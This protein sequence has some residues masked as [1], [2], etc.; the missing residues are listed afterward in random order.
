MSTLDDNTCEYCQGLGCDNC[1]HECYTCAGQGRVRDNSDEEYE[2]CPDC[3][4]TGVSFVKEDYDFEPETNMC[5]DCEGSGQDPDT[6]EECE[7]CAGVGEL[8]EAKDKHD[9]QN[10][11]DKHHVVDGNDYGIDNPESTTNDKDDNPIQVKES[12]G[13]VEYRDPSG[14]YIVAYIPP[15][16]YVAIGKGLYKGE[17]SREYFETLDDAIEHADIEISALQERKET[18]SKIHESLVYKYRSY[19]SNNE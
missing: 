8:F 2:T 19:R 1:K 10:G 6:G 16:G 3:D 15:K 14:H 18:V 17:I 13:T 12:K 9:M 11:Y 4:G 5:P 7:R